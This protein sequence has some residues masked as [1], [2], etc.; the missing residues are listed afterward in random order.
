VERQ[1]TVLVRFAERL[2]V[3]LH[4]GLDVVQAGPPASNDGVVERQP[5]VPPLRRRP[6]SRH[7][8]ESLAHPGND[9]RIRSSHKG[10]VQQVPAPSVHGVRQVQPRID[11]PRKVVQRPPSDLFTITR[12]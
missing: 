6:V 8:R 3:G 5:P 7:V 12:Q 11:P 1:V 2:R 10:A 4:H 9:A